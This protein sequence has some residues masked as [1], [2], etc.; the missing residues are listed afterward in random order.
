MRTSNFKPIFTF[1]LVPIWMSFEVFGLDELLI[2]KA[3]VYFGLLFVS[4]RVLMYCIVYVS[5][6]YKYLIHIACHVYHITS[7]NT[8][9]KC[10]SLKKIFRGTNNDYQLGELL[11]AELLS[12]PS[13][14]CCS[15][16]CDASHTLEQGS[17][18]QTHNAIWNTIR[19]NSLK[20]E[21]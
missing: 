14:D 11:R 16:L 5:K 7:I 1:F 10:W 15:L 2:R 18:K 4:Y 12:S 9:P 3:N 8:A 21:K 17:Q 20:H 13:A 6:N 19:G